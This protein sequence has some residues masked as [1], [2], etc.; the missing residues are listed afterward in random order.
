MT[1]AYKDQRDFIR[2]EVNSKVEFKRGDSGPILLGTAIDISAIGLRFVSEEIIEN[3]EVLNVTIYPGAEVTPP[4]HATVTVKRV[5]HC[6]EEGTYEIAGTLK[7][8]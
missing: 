2:M 3:E 7:M 4:L 6:E 5:D 1:L 8:A